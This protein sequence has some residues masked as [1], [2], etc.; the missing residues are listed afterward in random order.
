MSGS[1]AYHI[2]LMTG[3]LRLD[4][5]YSAHDATE[6]VGCRTLRKRAQGTRPA[7]GR[8]RSDG[9]RP[10]AAGGARQRYRAR[11]KG[12]LVSLDSG[13][14]G[15]SSPMTTAQGRIS[16]RVTSPLIT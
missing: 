12:Y 6:L 13:W 10:R 14:R 9:S 3:N 1:E 7:P 8:S 15:V 5:A 2:S 4:D 16:H 11:S